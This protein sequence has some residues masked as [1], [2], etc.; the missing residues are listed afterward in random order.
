MPKLVLRID[1]MMCE[2][3]VDNVRKALAAVPGVA[4]VDVKIG[5]ATLSYD[6]SVTDETAV[7][8]AVVDAGF[9][10]KVKKGLF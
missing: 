1:G 9:P 4:D 6:G 7:V 10:A 5:K 2:V 3:C 8:R